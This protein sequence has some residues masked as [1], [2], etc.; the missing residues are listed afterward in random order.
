M[1]HT[2]THS[3]SRSIARISTS[4]R[5]H[6]YFIFFNSISFCCFFSCFRPSYLI[7]VQCASFWLCC[8][9]FYRSL[10]PHLIKILYYIMIKR[11]ANVVYSVGIRTRFRLL[12]SCTAYY[13][14]HVVFRHFEIL[15]AF[16]TLNRVRQRRRRSQSERNR[17]A[18]RVQRRIV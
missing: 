4:R 9:F 12:C 8:S 3:F 17:P 14:L 1:L 16:D 5:F 6:F 11:V 15:H 7:N 2:L 18:K 13:L 10:S